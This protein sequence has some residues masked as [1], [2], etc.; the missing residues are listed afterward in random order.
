MPGKHTKNWAKQ[1]SSSFSEDKQWAGFAMLANQAYAHT[2]NIKNTLFDFKVLT[3]LAHTDEAKEA[4][5]HKLH[6]RIQFAANELTKLNSTLDYIAPPMQD[7]E[8]NYPTPSSTENEFLK[9]RQNFVF[10]FSRKISELQNYL[11]EEAHHS[12]L[13]SIK[14]DDMPSFELNLDKAITASH[15]LCNEMERAIQSLGGR[16]MLSPSQIPDNSQTR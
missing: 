10:K 9:S 16:W 3:E 7:T 14:T 13:A 5:I 6:G 15:L 8:K 2:N 1:P 4:L 11:P 12:L